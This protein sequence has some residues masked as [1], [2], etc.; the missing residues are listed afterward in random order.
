MLPQL[1]RLNY[2]L[3]NPAGRFPKKK[4]KI[5][6]IYIYIYIYIYT[7]YIYTVYIKQH[8]CLQ[9]CLLNT[10]LANCDDLRW[11][12]RPALWLLIFLYPFS[13]IKILKTELLN[14]SNF[15]QYVYSI[16]C[17]LGETSFRKIKKSYHSISRYFYCHSV[18]V[19]ISTPDFWTVVY[20]MMT[21]MMMV[22][23]III[24]EI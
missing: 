19:D 15:W 16:F 5:T 12:W 1:C 3:L 22:I 20:I 11:H 17:S 21:V 4:K 8:N 9:Q 6:Y 18:H 2:V 23:N 7:L 14:C 13:Y 24:I 10:K